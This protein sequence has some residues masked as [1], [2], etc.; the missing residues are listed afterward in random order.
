MNNNYLPQCLVTLIN[1]VGNSVFPISIPEALVQNLVSQQY[2]SVY[3][4]NCFVL[5]DWSGSYKVINLTF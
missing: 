5:W 2:L 1:E 3:R 4:H